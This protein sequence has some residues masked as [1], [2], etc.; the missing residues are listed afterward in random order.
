MCSQMGIMA[1]WRFEKEGVDRSGHKFEDFKKEFLS[2]YNKWTYFLQSINI[3]INPELWDK[4]F[5][6]RKNRTS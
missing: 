6:E 1:W 2:E 4:E 5:D 3:D